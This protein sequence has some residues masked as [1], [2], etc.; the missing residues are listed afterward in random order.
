MKTTK[1]ALSV[2]LAVLMIM[3]SMSVCFG[4][5]SFA[6][7]GSASAEQW[8]AL[9][10]ALANDTVKNADFSGST[11]NYT[12]EDPD[13]KIIAAVEAY[14]TVFNAIA[15]R[16]PACGNPAN[17]TN[18]TGST[19]GN[20]TINQIND[21]IKNEMSSRMGADYTNYNVATFLTKLLSGASVN[22]GTGAQQGGEDKNN[23]SSAPGTNLSA[24]A[25]IKLT[26]MMSSAITGYANVDELP[27]KVVTSKSFTVKHTN[28]N[29]D[30]TYSKTT[31]QETS[32]SGCNQTTTNVDYFTEYYK[33]FYNVSAVVSGVN[34]AEIDT[35]ILKD[36]GDILEQ[37]AAYF[38]MNMDE[39]YATPAATLDTV[40]SAVSTAKSNVV[41]NFGAGVFTHFF[42]AYKV[43]TLV[44]DIVI[45]KEIQI[46]A[47]K[48]LKAYEDMEKGYADIITDKAALTT[49]AATMTTAID[50]Y[51]AATPSA[52]AYCTTKGFIVADVT[53][54]R[55]AVL[56]E[57]E[58]IDLRALIAEIQTGIVPYL[59][60][61]EAG[62]DEG[63]VTTEM[64]GAALTKIAGWQTRLAAFA[65]A[66][67]ADI[68]GA[69]FKSG[70]T[71][72][73]SEMDY[74]KLVA[75]YNDN[76][77]AE[78]AKFAAEI[79]SVTD[80]NG[81]IATLLDALKNYDSW[82]TGLK[83][84]TAE[85]KSV[86]GEEL[87][88][89]LFDGLNDVMTARMDDAY[90][91]L[92][93]LLEEQI[94]Y[95]YDLFTAYTSA[96]GEKVTMATV[97]DYRAMKASIGLINA[98]A[99]NFLKGTA[100]FAISADAVAKYTAMQ[101]NF[102]QYDEFINSNGFATFQTNTIADLERPSM[103][104]DVARDGGYKTSDAE[105]EKII[106]LLDAA[107]GNDEVKNLLGQLINKDKETGEPTG[108]PFDLASLING[109]IEGIYTDSLINT[110]VQFVYPIVCKEFAKVW[111]GLPSTF[112]AY[113]VE[114]GVS[115][116]PT[117]NVENCPLY[118][119]DVET[120]I[121][122]V[123]LYLSPVKL[124]ANLKSNNAY[125]GYT[126][127]IAKLESATTKAVYN[128]NG[129]GDDDDT[130]TNPWEDAA[131][132]KNVYD[133]E[134][135]EQILNDD[136][137]PKQ[138]YDLNWGIDEAEDKR[139]AFINAACAAL[140]G[141]EPLLMAIIA[142]TT[143]VNPNT[144]NTDARG[145]K[146]GTGKGTASVKALGFLTLDLNLNIDPITL[147]L[148]F[149]GNDGWDNALAP[150]F[151][152]LGLENIPHSH[153][154]NTTRKLLEN[155]LFAMIDQLITKVSAAPVTFILEAIPN[156]CYALEGG[157][158]KP[159]LN[160]L[161]TEISY[162]ADAYYTGSLG[163]YEVAASVLK[164]A[165][166][167]DPEKPIKINIGEMINLDDLGLDIGSFQAIWDMIAGGVELLDGISAPNAGYIA[168][169]GKLVEKSTN[170]SAKTY[171]H[172][173]AGKA[174]HINA[175]KAD[176]L[177]YLLKYVIDS[178]LLG[179]FNLPSE[180]IVADILA[181]LQDNPDAILA[182]VVELFNLEKYDTL[183]DYT[184]YEGDV[185]ADGTTV[186]GLTP[187]M[188]EYLAYDNNWTKEKAEYL[189]N[190]IDAIIGAVAGEE[191]NL[192]TTLGDLIGGLF[193]NANITTIAGLLSKLD[194]NALLAGDAEAEEGEDANAPETV[195]EGEEATEEEA[196]ALDIDVAALLKAFT[197]LDFSKYAD[198]K[199]LAEDTTWGFED[200]DAAGFVAALVELLAP[201]KPVL[202]FILADADLEI[203]L[204]ADDKVTLV[205]YNGYDSAI[206]PLL[207][208]LGCEV[209]ALGDNDALTLV[210]NALVAKIDAI[211]ADPINEIL[212]ILPG[213]IYF[214][215]SNGLATVVRNLLQPI[216]VILDTIRP[217]YDLDIAAL[218]AGIKIDGKP[219]SIN[220]DDLGW[221]FIINDLLPNFLAIDLGDFNTLIADVCKVI[222]V[223]Y[224]SVSTVVGTGKK[225]AYN[226]NFDKAD[227]LTVIVCFAL[228]W[229]QKDGNADSVVALIAGDD[230]EK[231][232]EISGYING[233]FNVI[234][235][236]EVSYDP[237]NWAY[238]FPEGFDD[239]I[240]STGIQIP[241][242]LGILGYPTDWTEESAKYIADNLDAIVADVLA[243]TGAEGS[244]SDML[245]SK[246][247]IFNA[248]TLKDLIA[249]IADLLTKIDA[250]LVETVGVVLGAD[251]DAI[252]NYEVSEDVDTAEEFFATL[253]DILSNIQ[254]VVDWLFFGEDFRLFNTSTG[255]DAIVLTGT[256]G[257]AYG[258]APILE[259]LG[260]DVPAKDEA[261]VAD[262]LGAIAA[263]YEEIIA[264]PIDEIFGLLPNVI[265]FL[266]A[267]GVSV[268]VKN[269][270][271]GV[272]GLMASVKENFGVELD[273]FAII[274]DALNN[275]LPEDSDVEI[276]A[277]N[278]DLA[279]IIALVEAL[280]GI[281]LTA[282]SKMLVNFCV[283]TIE[284]YTSASGEYA[285]RMVY[286]D[287]FEKH[288]MLTILV[289]LAL[290]VV[291]DA[292]NAAALKDLLGEDIYNGIIDIFGGS[293][294][295]YAEINWDYMDET[296]NYVVTYPNNWT[297]E[298]ADY[299]A[300]IL[301]DNSEIDALVAGLIGE[302]NSLSEVLNDKVNVFTADTLN[303]LVGTIT[304]LL[305]DISDNLLGVG[306]LLNVDLV[307]LKAY[308][309]D[310]S[311]DTVDEFAAEFANILNTYAKGVVEWLL[312]G[313]DYAFG[314]DEDKLSD[315]VPYNAEDA[316]ITIT[317]AH[318][319]AEG[320]ALLLEALGC[321]N[322]PAVY[323]TEAKTED[324]VNAVFASV[325]ARINEI[326]ADPITEVIELLPNLLYFLNTNG[327]ASVIKNTT[328]AV[329]AIVDKLGAFGVELDINELVNLKKIMKIEDTDAAISL[330][331][332]SMAA[333]LEAVSLMVG[334]DLTHIES[335]LVGFDLG[336]VVTYTSVSANVGTPKKM[337]YSDT[338][339][340]SDM[341]TV[342]ANIVLNTISD[343][344]NKDFV[345]N[346]VGEDI[347]LVI[348]NLFNMDSEDI[349]VPVQDFDWALTDKADT[350]YVF[351]AFETSTKFTGEVYGDFYTREMA[352]YIAD[353]FGDFVNN[354]IY[355]LGL[356]VNGDGS[357]ETD[358][359]E[360]INGLVNGNVYNSANIV[361]IRDAL[362]GVL[363]SIGNLEVK[364]KNV[365]KYIVE[366][367]AKSGVA[368]FNAVSKVEV[369]E[370]TENRALFVEY[371]CKV[372]EPLYPVL[373]FV[374]A[375][376]D[377]S[378][379]VNADKTDAITL[380]GAEGY[381][382]GI[383]PLLE[384]L[385]CE[386]LKAPEAYYAAVKADG[387]ALLTSIL[388]P[389]L[390][391]VDEIL[392]APADEILA[393]L[394]N[395][396]YF[397]N[398][399][400]VDTV[401][402]NTLNAVYTVLNA[403]SPIAKIDLYEIIG[404]DLAT[405][406][407]NWILDKL[408]EV[409]EG[410][411]YSFNV[412]DL[413]A[414]SELTV[415]TLESYTSL[416]G[417]LAYKMVYTDAE[418][419]AGGKT[420]MVTV[421]ERL[422]ITFLADPANQKAAVQFL[423]DKM[424][425][426]DDAA[427]YV[428][429][430]IKVIAETVDETSLGM[431]MALSTVYYVFTG[432][433]AG[434]GNTAGGLKDLNDAWK[435][436]IGDL[437]EENPAA[438]ELIE[439]IL[440]WDVLED[441]IDTDK[442]VAPNGLIKFFQSIANI[443]KAIG[444][445]FSKLF[446][447]N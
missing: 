154:L 88:E 142:D 126:Q 54:F 97:S 99:Y 242:T 219:L 422:A 429:G 225:G 103:E 66:D 82:Y 349:Q 208:A 356:D 317:G 199:E 166:E 109:L 288:D 270:L 173:T 22:A 281:D 284:A 161:K 30:Y 310:A 92:N 223:E 380:T 216:Y 343:E 43:E 269:L 266:N 135:G 421:I 215:Q 425:M 298:T 38:S 176:V 282:V 254:P 373:K 9:A 445:F 243:L 23:D 162:F 117:A 304:G 306:V 314:V 439:E 129:E 390:D 207:E 309:A 169:L 211:I 213:V 389:L 358:L 362:A 55:T 238:N 106:D 334:I 342:L 305:K 227:L 312:L 111:A 56:R 25:D 10:D 158:V 229:I 385:D 228:E 412:E 44:S 7:G 220:L 107:L 396:I 34:G 402:K 301:D 339:D 391:R 127:V 152:A 379:F 212:D 290:V 326:F 319:Y 218:L 446:G 424:G 61:N 108:E 178:G 118:L 328:A 428:E 5:V 180:G 74:L 436:A 419:A 336:A 189:I 340:K 3:S 348:W 378:F 175:N 36:S 423:K 188:L 416:N 415:G 375:N 320:L 39:L 426:S 141:I 174:Y 333:I 85:M 200:G 47:P 253:A 350:G 60:Y 139:A 73:K 374:L 355:L 411:G 265:Y 437:K 58:L 308:K 400:G 398:S 297:E 202:D 102:P 262:V 365:G 444:N 45:A 353:N 345:L 27:A 278:L 122:A 440:G 393:M 271:A 76:F 401:V 255:A 151:E 143:Y 21:T 246:I 258:L 315:N 259:A 235:G 198:Y 404:V 89:E 57:I 359:N 20:R 197:G 307:G 191:F 257:Y 112:S 104:G 442:G 397:V 384:A 69:D 214:I 17:D 357:S 322:L 413:S 329:M 283:G 145:S 267:N 403:I 28:T 105:I 311:I 433:D 263:R 177:V 407:F 87:A 381:A 264:D 31:K 240:Y 96:N 248:K 1:K 363:A 128:L 432:V 120:S 53:A 83:A 230:A 144:T 195:A 51:N 155:G 72:V 206:V 370:F 361:A 383:L 409:L 71:A 35:Q 318:G 302:Y 296:P 132:F 414:I 40:S 303:S 331:N 256:E 185:K 300:A 205:G 167:S 388:N 360:L 115:V 147:V 399:N 46:L 239:A 313:R 420:E 64:I 84:L 277:Q 133:E 114:T 260:A 156:L 280:V 110:I 408:L 209:E 16:T 325:A 371:L 171:N 327:V 196:A 291:S 91:A 11:N 33:Y 244:L 286:D 157:L 341:V 168:T 406:D 438:G 250:T 134:T 137:T 272:T 186:T 49:L 366:V 13:G 203:A 276:D 279:T 321:E 136:G 68:G 159:L 224:N 201:L 233:A 113:N 78:Y 335:V 19:E 245:K 316:I 59:T 192:S 382:Y 26:V 386:G 222:G 204:S 140:S 190:N 42:S 187:A 268:S 231:A 184:W 367:L 337:V 364:G 67:I 236:I 170:R 164:N 372:L 435:E 182:A 125:K 29:Y 237:I 81:D 124:A 346:L 293:V 70:L 50:A 323:G 24:V 2:L 299:V 347:Y 217:I 94:D 441:I 79:F 121:A 376:E 100:N 15:N 149:K 93:A 344:D 160:M 90:V 289:T 131:L 338:F 285:F 210:L 295:E 146:I 241:S 179:K 330:D 261:T 332:L 116:A 86:L 430:L 395:I 37:Y 417:K 165:M 52:K 32:G 392:A 163:S 6:A 62:I 221:N 63:T 123:G 183:V 153:E 249:L 369:P 14:Y 368:D 387:S 95:A 351:S 138:V 172:G 434:V 431:Q 418:M 394:P 443:F 226:D 287:S 130:F 447:R 275:L 101:K 148:T 410:M 41:N 4:T 274:N 48:L 77:S 247:N 18:V 232:A 234:K 252:V 352:Q 193:T 273:L 251:I 427:K 75:G 98:D 181:N 377:F 12:V 324:I 294:I 292:D 65:D 119:N 8:N 80:A 194:L 354:I 150:I 405:I